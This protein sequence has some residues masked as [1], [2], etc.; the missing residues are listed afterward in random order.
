MQWLIVSKKVEWQVHAQDIFS[1]LDGSESNPHPVSGETLHDT[2]HK[3]I[4]GEYT[5]YFGT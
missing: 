3:K 2:V 4:N 5:D 1:I